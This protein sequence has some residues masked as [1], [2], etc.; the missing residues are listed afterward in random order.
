[1][2]EQVETL[3]DLLQQGLRAVVI[4]INPSTVS[5]AA[6]HYY[7]GTLGKKLWQRLQQAGLLDEAPSGSED[8]AA[9]AAGIGFTDIVK[10]A[11]ARADSISHDEFDYG[12]DLLEAKLSKH[13]P[14][15][16]IFAFQEDR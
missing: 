15:L 9:F 16:V 11:S 1:M 6:G 4:G 3:E 14:G 10:R 13:Q 5:V 12:R 8:D 7:Q 2:G